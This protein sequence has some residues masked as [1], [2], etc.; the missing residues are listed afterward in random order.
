MTFERISFTYK[1][2]DTQVTPQQFLRSY[3]FI[4][5][6]AVESLKFQRKFQDS[7][8][9]NFE[10]LIPLGIQIEKDLN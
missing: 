1:V 3:N 6:T 2:L 5:E 10:F 7:F 9:E 4:F 8:G